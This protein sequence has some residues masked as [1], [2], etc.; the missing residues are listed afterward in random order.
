MLAAG[1]YAEGCGSLSQDNGWF[2][3]DRIYDIL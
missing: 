3:V 1:V 2:Y